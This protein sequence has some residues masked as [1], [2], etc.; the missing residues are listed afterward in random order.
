[1]LI[2]LGGLLKLDFEKA[3]DKV[4]WHFLLE[5]LRARGFSDRWI[6]WIKIGLMSGISTVL[7][8]GKEGRKFVCKKGLRQGD[9]LSP[10]LF[11]LVANVFTKMVHL[12]KHNNFIQGLGKFDN[13][14]LSLQYVD[15]IIMFSSDDFPKLRNLKLI[16]YLFEGI[17][18]M[19]IFSK[20][21]V[22][23][24]DGIAQEQEEIASFFNCKKGTYPSTYL[25]I[26][27]KVGKLVKSDWNPLL[28]KV[29]KTL[30][31][32]K[33]TC[34]SRGGRLTLVNAGLTNIPS[35]WMSLLYLPCWVVNRIDQIRRDILWSGSLS[36]SGIR[37]L[38]NWGVVCRSKAQGGL[39]I[40]NIGTL[41][42]WVNGFGRCLLVKIT[43]G[44]SLLVRFF[45][46][47]TK[48]YLRELSE[49]SLFILAGCLEGL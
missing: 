40:I 31:N 30:P 18:G 6:N 23:R 10:L 34:L 49:R 44:L 37:C 14:L 26:P 24:L 15:D 5:L 2:S 45:I 28:D 41:L 3:C 29:E 19:N 17:S 47:K 33:C 35:Y 39:G 46:H 20:S 36:V 22:I 1:M 4:N 48:F 8:N 7:V 12:G 9:P 13:G 38:R 11:V 32:W 21:A 42:S 27:L 25:G 43:R 16:L